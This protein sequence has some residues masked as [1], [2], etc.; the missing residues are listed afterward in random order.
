MKRIEFTLNKNKKKVNCDSHAFT[1]IFA[2]ELRLA[3]HFY[4]HICDT[5][6]NFLFVTVLTF[7]SLSVDG[8]AQRRSVEDIVTF[9]II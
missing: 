4:L 2:E 3:G 6:W 7:A 1:I 9:W 5:S 8:V